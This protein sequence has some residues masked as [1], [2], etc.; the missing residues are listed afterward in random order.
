MPDY[1]GQFG[2]SS[3]YRNPEVTLPTPDAQDIPVPIWVETNVMLQWVGPVAGTYSGPVVF[4]DAG[5][6][7]GLN[8]W[9]GGLYQ[10]LWTTP[11]FDLRPDLR[12]GQG[13]QKNGV[14]IWRKDAKLYIQLSNLQNG[15]ASNIYGLRVVS[16]EF[17][18]TVYATITSRP[19]AGQANSVILTTPNVDVGTE[20]SQPAGQPPSVVV[21]IAPPGTSA[22]GGGD[23]PVRYWRFAILF[24]TRSTG[25][26]AGDPSA[27]TPTAPGLLRLQAA[28]Y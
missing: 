11:I 22:G 2:G 18:D 7:V 4:T 12:S 17:A 16:R 10:I 15:N 19:D 6:I 21:T 3:L 23:T 5:P 20:I 25:V 26:V 13:G 27:F 14:P 1:P 8:Q 24:E 9:V 28:V